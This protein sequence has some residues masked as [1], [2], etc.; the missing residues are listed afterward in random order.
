MITYLSYCNM[1]WMLFQNMLCKGM[2]FFQ[3]YCISLGCI[4]N[5]LCMKCSFTQ[6][7]NIL[8][9][10]FF[11]IVLGNSFVFFFSICF[12]SLC[13]NLIM[14]TQIHF[15][16]LLNL[17]CHFWEM[18]W[19]NLLFV[20]VRKVTDKEYLENPC[21]YSLYKFLFKFLQ[22]FIYLEKCSK[23]VVLVFLLKLFSLSFL[24]KLLFLK[25]DLHYILF[26]YIFPKHTDFENLVFLAF[27]QMFSCSFQNT[28]VQ[29]YRITCFEILFIYFTKTL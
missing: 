8:F 7:Q 9:L 2:I 20:P 22:Y 26:L 3:F 15:L 11:G 24:C 29:W 14:R 5:E 23:F 10:Q 6:F 21:K 27:S 18:H 19:G 12:L 1:P 16:L 28:F 13:N 17:L 25:L 4:I